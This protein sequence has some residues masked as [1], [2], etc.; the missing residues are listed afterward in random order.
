IRRPFAE[1]RAACHVDHRHPSRP[2]VVLPQSLPNPLTPQAARQTLRPVG[3][4]SAKRM[5]ATRLAVLAAA[6][7]FVA[8]PA[9]AKTLRWSSD[10]DVFSLDPYA[11]Q[12]TFLLSFDSNIYEPL[13][14]RGRGFRLEPALATA[15][16]QMAPDR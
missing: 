14:R 13:V 4:G 1:R 9:A 10:L 8:L 12:E 11:R 6:L 3:N 5:T 16:S 15:W 7:L 2:P